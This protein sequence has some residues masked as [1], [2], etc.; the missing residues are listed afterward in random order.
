M[1]DSKSASELGTN[2]GNSQRGSEK[3]SS[4]ESQGSGEARSKEFQASCSE[5]ARLEKYFP[6]IEES[7]ARRREAQFFKEFVIDGYIKSLYEADLP[8][9]WYKR[10]LAEIE[11]FTEFLKERAR[12]KRRQEQKSAEDR[13]NPST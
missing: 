2:K 6:S 1:E 5:R 12:E 11:A 9:E 7:A 3:P 8:E 13:G 4:G 10:E